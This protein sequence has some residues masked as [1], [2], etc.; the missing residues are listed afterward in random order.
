[1]TIDQLLFRPGARAAG[2]RFDAKNRAA[3]W[4]YLKA[5][6]DLILEV[7]RAYINALAAE[8]QAE[9]AREGA[10]MAAAQMEQTKLM[11]AAGSAMERDVKASDGDLADAEQGV[12]RAENGVRAAHGNL[13]RV[14]G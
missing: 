6:N 8:A 13:N 14:L 12:L 3:H 1:L 5:E 11:L 2:A 10:K 7:R 9:V 4:E